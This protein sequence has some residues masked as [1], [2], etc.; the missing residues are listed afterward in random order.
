ML[1]VSVVVQSAKKC[2]LL[3]FSKREPF[4][5]I[6]EKTDNISADKNTAAA[7]TLLRCQWNY[8]MGSSLALSCNMSQ[9][10]HSWWLLFMTP[11]TGNS[12]DDF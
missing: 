6:K 5:K 1:E 2:F 10:P 4:I 12:S 7:E 8:E 11:Q 9:Q 3:L